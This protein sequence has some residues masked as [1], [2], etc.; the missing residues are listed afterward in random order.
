MR[1]CHNDW[2]LIASREAADVYFGRWFENFHYALA[3]DF[4][5]NKNKMRKCITNSE[6][7]MQGQILLNNDI[8]AVCLRNRR[9]VRLLN[10]KEIKRDVDITGKILFTPW[11]TNVTK[12]KYDLV[13]RWSTDKRRGIARSL[14]MPQI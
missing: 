5:Q 9:D 4:L 11:Q 2:T 14:K 10:K 13:K 7:S 3:K 12:L 8:Q 1:L 6:H